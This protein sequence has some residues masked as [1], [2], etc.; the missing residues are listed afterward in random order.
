MALLVVSCWSGYAQAVVSSKNQSQASGFDLA[1]QRL[2]LTTYI[3]T[4]ANPNASGYWARWNWDACNVSHDP[5]SVL[6]DGKRDIASVY[7]P[8]IGPYDSGDDSVI[9]YHMRLAQASGIDVFVVDWYGTKNFYDFPQQNRKFMNMMRIAERVNFGIAVDYDA[10]KFYVGEPGQSISKVLI[11][12][13]SEALQAIHDDIA[14]IIEKFGGSPAYLKFDGKPVIF[15]FS[16]YDLQPKTWGDIFESLRKQ[17]LDAFY[18]DM[19]GN[20]NYY[21]YF[22]GFFP[23]IWADAIANGKINSVSYINEAARRLAEFAQGRSISLGLGVWPGFDDSAVGGWCYD[24]GILKI[25]RM[26]GALYNQTWKTALRSAPAWIFIITFND[27]SE[28]TIIEPSL[29]FGYQYLYA[30]AYFAGQLKKQLPNLDGVPVP[31]AIYNATQAIRQAEKKGRIVGLE[32]ASGRLQQAKEA[33]DSRHYLDALALANQARQLASQASMPQ[34]F[35]TTTSSISTAFS[36]QTSFLAANWSLQLVGLV[37]IVT[38]AVALLYV[39]RRKTH[40]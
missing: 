31:L 12:N 39:V 26:S 34:L 36:V 6:P 28:G 40:R 13:K 16:N 33:F 4:W 18:V 21:P 11:P 9:E 8:L 30:T 29:E 37:G 32:D 22:R 2:V 35:Q 20:T 23:W 24:R 5:N 7:Y 1:T 17:G 38:I 3:D 25:G 14:Y 19:Q 15:A 27:W 10:T